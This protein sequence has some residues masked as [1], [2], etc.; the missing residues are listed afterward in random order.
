MKQSNGES[1]TNAPPAAQSM[2]NPEDKT[3]FLSPSLSIA[4]RKTPSTIPTHAKGIIRFAVCEMRSAILYS[5]GLRIPVYI[6]IIKKTRSFDPKTPSPRTNVFNKSFLY[7]AKF[8]FIDR[9]FQN[10]KTIILYYFT[11]RAISQCFFSNLNNFFHFCFFKG[12][13]QN[14]KK[15]KTEPFQKGRA[16]LAEKSQNLSPIHGR[17]ELCSP[18]GDRRSPLRIKMLRCKQ[19]SNPDRFLKVCRDLCYFA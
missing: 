7:L 4:K 17:G 6:G 5:A 1:N 3:A 9:P 11:Y 10:Y 2:A 15:E 12:I 19:I 8:P 14:I 13:T 16:N 18:A